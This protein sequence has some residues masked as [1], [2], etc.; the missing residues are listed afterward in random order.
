M[1]PA[2]PVTRIDF[3]LKPSF[4][5]NPSPL[6]RTRLHCALIHN[7]NIEMSYSVG[8]CRGHVAANTMSEKD[9]GQG[10]ENLPGPKSGAP[11]AKGTRPGRCAIR[12]IGYDHSLNIAMNFKLKFMPIGY[13]HPGCLR[14]GFVC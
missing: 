2:P 12:L 8:T 1:L 10:E 11:R 4:Y 9:P 3:L 5:T 6:Q 13:W 7:S 14:R